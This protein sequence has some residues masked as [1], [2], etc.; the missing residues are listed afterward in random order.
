MSGVSYI[1]VAVCFFSL[2]LAFG[3]LIYAD[4]GLITIFWYT[5][6]ILVACVISLIFVV[7]GHLVNVTYLDWSA[8]LVSCTE[9]LTPRSEQVRFP[10]CNCKTQCLALRALES[11]PQHSV[12]SFT[13]YPRSCFH[14]RIR[15]L[16]VEKRR[17]QVSPRAEGTE[18]GVRGGDNED[19]LA[20]Y[21]YNTLCFDLCVCNH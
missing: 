16:A 8:K 13:S 1:L 9:E 6:S 2:P 10:Q 18:G 21:T 20:A 7:V 11:Y 12:C 15:S 3:R 14:A 17:D 19:E 4:A 5:I